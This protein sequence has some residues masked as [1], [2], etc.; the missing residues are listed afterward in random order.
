MMASRYTFADIAKK[1]SFST[2]PGATFFI[3][4]SAISAES[5]GSWMYEGW[6]GLQR[7]E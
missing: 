1:S 2:V 6:M 7:L 3:T 4:M 5:A